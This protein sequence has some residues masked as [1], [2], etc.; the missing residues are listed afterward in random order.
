MLSPAR[1]TLENNGKIR[2]QPDRENAF[3]GASGGAAATAVEPSLAPTVARRAALIPYWV[4]ELERRL[5][6]SSSF[7]LWASGRLYALLRIDSD[8]LLIGMY[9][10]LSPDSC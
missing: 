4:C 6:T 10:K 3:A 2:P 5:F 9:A 1:I 8:T 7:A